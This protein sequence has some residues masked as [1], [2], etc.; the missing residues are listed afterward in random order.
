M[1]GILVFLVIMSRKCIEFS[2]FRSGSHM[3]SGLTNQIRLF[4]GENMQTQLLPYFYMKLF[5]I[6]FRMCSVFHQV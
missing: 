5:R 6:V 1:S 3:T 4:L 2:F